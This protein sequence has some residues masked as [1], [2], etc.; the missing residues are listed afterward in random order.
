VGG[1]EFTGM[2]TWQTGPFLTPLWT[3]A[4]P[5]GI[6]YTTSA[7]SPNTTLRPN[8]ARNPNLAPDGRTLGRWF[9]TSAF[10]APLAGQFGSAG[11]G[12]IVGPGTN[13]WN[14]GIF[15][16]LEFFEKG[17]RLRWEL[18]AANML[19]HPNWGAPGL[20]LSTPSSFGKITSTQ[21]TG[22]FG[23]DYRQ[24]RTALRLEW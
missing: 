16:K 5:V 24:L 20:N 19:N 7:T 6:S 17:P 13:G 9:D 23:P 3:G 2:F 22:T 10:S 11:K 18:T 12:I 4:D 15:K 21:T 1:W 14:A 8:V